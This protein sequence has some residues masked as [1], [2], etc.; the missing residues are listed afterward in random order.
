MAPETNK[1]AK[2][3]TTIWLALIGGLTLV[4]AITVAIAVKLR[5][6]DVLPPLKTVGKELKAEFGEA[7]TE[8]DVTPVGSGASDDV[9]REG[10]RRLRD[11]PR[12]SAG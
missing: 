11:V 8:G 3:P 2:N 12:E 9:Q 6:A 4:L 7:L 10:L 5:D 1:N